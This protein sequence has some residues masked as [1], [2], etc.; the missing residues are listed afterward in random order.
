MLRLSKEDFG[1][2][3][4]LQTKTEKKKR[5][6]FEWHSNVGSCLASTDDFQVACLTALWGAE[7][8]NEEK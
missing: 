2:P 5:R 6:N 8:K 7:G 4:V 3:F 1:L